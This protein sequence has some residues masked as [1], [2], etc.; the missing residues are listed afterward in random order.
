MEKNYKK[1]LTEVDVDKFDSDEFKNH[2]KFIKKHSKL[3]KDKEN[4]GN[5]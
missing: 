5:K 4:K 3:G 2:A 1:Y